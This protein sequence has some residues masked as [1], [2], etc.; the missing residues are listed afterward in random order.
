MEEQSFQIARADANGECPGSCRMHSIAQKN[1]RETWPQSADVASYP[2]GNSRSIEA[3]SIS[4]AVRPV[5]GLL[6][7]SG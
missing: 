1:D 4:I 7:A 2:G 3:R 6:P 5:L